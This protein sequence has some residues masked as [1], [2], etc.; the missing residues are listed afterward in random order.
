MGT[1]L[2]RTELSLLG[3]FRLTQPG[4]K[5]V[6]LKGQKDRAL[7]AFLALPP[8]GPHTRDKLAGLLWG[9]RGDQQARD[10]LKHSLTR[11]RQCLEVAG[12][13]SIIADRQ[14]VTL[15]PATIAI[16]VVTF[17]R[18]LATGTAASLAEAMALYAGDLLE[19]LSIANSSF[20][21]WLLVERQR[22]RRLFE[23][24]LSK[25]L[26]LAL[27]TRT[28]E[29]AV[30]VARRLLVLDP[31][32]EAACRA[33]M[34]IHAERA[35]TA[36]ALSVFEAMRE[37]LH[38]E[39]GI[40]PEADT[41]R[42]HEAIR[43]RRIRPEVSVPP[44]TGMPPPDKPSVAVM[45][46]ENVSGDP[47]QQYFSNGITEDIIT[48]LSRF[49][50]L[51]VIARHSSFAFK[52]TQSSIREIASGLGVAYVVEGSVRRAGSRVRI[53]AQLIDACT[54][55]HLWA[56][57]YDREMRD[58]FAVQDDAARSVA[59]AVSGR[60]EAAG[61]DRV[62]RLS[63]DALTAYDYVLRAKALTSNYTRTD[64]ARALACAERAVELDPSSARAHTHSAW[65]H[66]YDYM[67]CW[68]PCRQ[69]GGQGPRMLLGQ[70][71]RLGMSLAR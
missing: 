8:Y 49:R 41:L 51:F 60:V 39:L 5:V 26:S 24:A 3:G 43:R 25:G 44:G 37:R 1:A 48:E 29:A 28:L 70:L 36:Q 21:D 69:I 6:G 62:E 50:S 45:P 63:P 53:G 16:D 67:A 40:E 42:L 56:E 14:S 23:E 9:D 12:S 20:D 33:L 71:V 58:I 19:G 18:L 11:L 32:H 35:Q 13:L 31:L 46:F 68:T 27:E 30:T 17:E 7:L 54:L 57:R 15:D 59:S 4:S 61:R 66:F 22:L 52:S 55:A 34:Q 2:A 47:E 64:N 10:S 65:C 38:Q